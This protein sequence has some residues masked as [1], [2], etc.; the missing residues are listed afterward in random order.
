MSTKI[1][2]R[3]QPKTSS[4]QEPKKTVIQQ[5][6]KQDRESVV[7]DAV[8]AVEGA[9]YNIKNLRTKYTSDSYYHK[10]RSLI[11]KINTHFGWGA[12]ILPI[13]QYEQNFN[14]IIEFIMESYVIRNPEMLSAKLSAIRYPL[15]LY[16]YDGDFMHKREE[17]KGIE[18]AQRQIG[19]TENWSSMVQLL[20]NHIINCCHPGGRIVAL[21]YKNGYFVSMVDMI[22]T[23]VDEFD[24]GYNYLDFEK[25]LWT[26]QADIN[27]NRPG[28]VITVSKEF[29]DIVKTNIR[30]G[31]VWLISKKGGFQYTSPVAMK[32]LGLS[33]FNLNQVKHAYTNE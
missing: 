9:G 8:D 16:E 20:D 26:I 15:K 30:K 6:Q 14:K 32:H 24:E 23:K 12:D 2:I 29:I 25:L 27:K 28:V 33:G 22:R 1:K 10:S 21:A 31:S 4:V 13:K 3:I 5:K 17:L 7:V 19:E 11:N 18:Y